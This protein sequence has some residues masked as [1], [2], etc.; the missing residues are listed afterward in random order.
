MSKT[1]IDWDSAPEG[2]P[3]WIVNKNLEGGEWYRDDGDLWRNQ[4]GGYYWKENRSIQ[5]YVRQPASE[6]IDPFQIGSDCVVT[7]HN[8]LWGFDSMEPVEAKIAGYDGDYIW[9]LVS[10]IKYI[11]T[12]TDKIDL[13]GFKTLQEMHDNDD[14]QAI[15]EMLSGAT[16]GENSLGL[17]KRL[18]RE[19]WRKVGGV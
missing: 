9:L 1:D 14:R 8:L 6:A 11:T 5:V 13:L 12:R 18:Y 15:G 3:V 10:D 4:E 17:C 16:P 2:Y 19:G 7:P